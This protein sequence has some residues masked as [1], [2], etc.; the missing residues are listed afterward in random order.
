M[1][2]CVRPQPPARPMCVLLRLCRLPGRGPGGITVALRALLEDAS[3]KKL[4]VQ[5][6]GDAHKIMRDFKVCVRP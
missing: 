1:Q 2:F 4:G 6:T 3:V 5:S